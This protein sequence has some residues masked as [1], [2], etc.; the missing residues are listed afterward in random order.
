MMRRPDSRPAAAFTLIELLVV[1]S[2]ISVLAAMLLPALT[3]AKSKAKRTLCVTNVK[4]QLAG[5]SL[6]AADQDSNIMP[7]YSSQHSG[8]VFSWTRHPSTDLG[9]DWG[10]IP[11]FYSGLGLLSS[12][13]AINSP[14]NSNGKRMPDRDPV[15]LCP[16][17]DWF[18]P[19][20]T[21]RWDFGYN[22]GNT[23]CVY[24]RGTYN[25]R[26]ASSVAWPHGDEPRMDPKLGGIPDVA[27]IYDTGHKRWSGGANTSNHIE[28]SYTVGY[29]DGSVISVADPNWVRTA[30]T[31]Y[32]DSAIYP[33]LDRQR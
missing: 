13:G 8:Q 5:I 21:Y 17:A 10:A 26:G 31:T 4:Q 23:T 27:A 1:V 30:N 18:K 16:L 12:T 32:Y 19:V 20:A 25:Y 29:Y 28:G 2:I 11:G 7:N 33:W 22:G 24:L 6:Y 9:R 15:L 3:K 14:R